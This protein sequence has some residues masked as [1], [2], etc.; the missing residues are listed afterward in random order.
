MKLLSGQDNSSKGTNRVAS[1]IIRILATSVVILFVIIVVASNRNRVTLSNFSPIAILISCFA[2]LGIVSLILIVSRILVLAPKTSSGIKL[3]LF[4][5]QFDQ[6]L[7]ILDGGYQVIYANNRYRDL[8]SNSGFSNTLPPLFTLFESA[9]EL[10]EGLYRLKIAS[11]QQISSSEEFRIKPIDP[12]SHESNGAQKLAQWVKISVQP[13]GSSGETLWLI[14]DITKARNQQEEFFRSLQDAINH[15]DQSP[16][17]FFAINDM[18]KLTF[19]NATFAAEIGVDLADFKPDTIPLE[20]FIF[21]DDLGVILERL[22]S[23]SELNPSQC[24]VRLMSKSQQLLNVQLVFQTQLFADGSRDLARFIVIPETLAQNNR[25]D[26]K[27]EIRVCIDKYLENSLLAMALIDDHGNVLKWNKHFS[28]LM[29]FDN[30][31]NTEVSTDKLNELVLEKDGERIVKI[32]G[33]AIYH[34]S[35][36][37]IDTAVAHNRD[38][39]IKLYVSPIPESPSVAKCYIV[40]IIE[41]TEQKVFEEQMAQGQKL[42][43][44]GQLAG[45]IAHDFNNVL[46]AIIMSCDLLLSNHRSSDPSHPDL[47]N[48]K[49][50]ANRAAALVQQ[51]LAFSRRQT[52]RPEIL[53]LTDLLSDIRMLILRLLGQNVKLQIIHGR[54]LWRVEVDQASFQRVIMNLAI[55]ARDAMPDG[56]IITITTSNLDE[57]ASHAVNERGFVHGDYVVIAVSDTGTGISQSVQEKMFEPFF[58]TKEVGKGTGLGLSM[59]YGI[60]KQTGGYI[61]C[62]SVIGQGTTFRIYLPRYLEDRKVGDGS[63]SQNNLENNKK[64]AKP[65]DLSG[66]ATILVVEDEDAVRLGSV[67]A[68]RSRGYT[69]LEATTGLEALEVLDEYRKPVDLVVSDVVMP[70]MDGPTLFQEVRKLYPEIKF[71]FVSGYARDAFANK[72]LDDSSFGFLAKPFSLKELASTVKDTLSKPINN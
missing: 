63:Q 13:I 50:N 67:R 12:P 21:E 4:I 36:F 51:L 68:L 1:L 22:N 66:S 9:Q 39:H 32:L 5:D 26:L 62:D 53:D 8:C 33:S 14:E 61:F 28:S 56:G 15:L 17:G 2:V 72:V 71:I 35:G 69:V 57:A 29:H 60:V 11:R 65:S 7:L 59:V 16:L 58:T 40:T 42:Q 70:E 30:P 45:G 52:L 37:E 54:D 10:N 31:P 49:N 23:T 44:V 64:T 6:A 25:T 55:N 34:N 19:L 3:N 27:N 18:N 24:N 41:T 48:I 20:R 47:I 46:T 43:A 38:Q